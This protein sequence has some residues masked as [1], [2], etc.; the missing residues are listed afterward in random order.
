MR[1]GEFCRSKR[2]ARAAVARHA[3]LQAFAADA[4]SQGTSSAQRSRSLACCSASKAQADGHARGQAHLLW[5]VGGGGARGEGRGGGGE[6]GGGEG[7]G[8]R[9]AHELALPHEKDAVVEAIWQRAALEALAYLHQ[10]GRW[11]MAKAAAGGQTAAAAAEARPLAARP[12]PTA[13]PP[14]FSA[15]CWWCCPARRTDG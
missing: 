5:G 14:S 1:S 7:G 2:Q 15:R 13:R 4:L 9:G 6:R 11:V 8:G 10:G 12:R 3:V